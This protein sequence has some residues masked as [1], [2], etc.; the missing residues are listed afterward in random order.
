MSFHVPSLKEPV[1]FNLMIDGVY[2][3]D[4]L[5]FLRRTLGPGDVF[6]DVGA[7]VGVFAL[8]ATH[9]VGPDGRVIAI[10]G[11]ARVFEYLRYNASQP[12]PG[13]V[14]CVH[15]AV[16]AKDAGMRKF[17]DPP[18]AKF[19]MGSLAAWPGVEGYEVPARTLDAVLRD[20]GVGPVKLIKV[21]VEGFEHDVFRGAAV[22]LATNPAPVI[23]F[24]F[25][26]WAERRAG[27]NPGA[28]QRLL[29]SQ[30]YRLWRL[31]KGGVDYPPLNGPL[32]YGGGMLVARKIS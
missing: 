21:D 23:L 29:L 2:E 32:E 10:E 6:V 3:P 16:T 15:T 17:F 4:T 8:P 5:E 31:E 7:N 28:A 14:A 9:L 25:L 18:A 24:E 27:H 26:D 30:G 12:C 19:G 11:S 20:L 1:A 13:P 22:A